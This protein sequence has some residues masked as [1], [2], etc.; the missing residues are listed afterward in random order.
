MPSIATI[1]DPARADHMFVFAVWVIVTLYI[2]FKAG[3]VKAKNQHYIASCIEIFCCINFI[4]ACLFWVFILFSC[5]IIILK[6]HVNVSA[7]TPESIVEKLESVNPEY[8]IQNR[9]N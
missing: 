6:E 3:T 1:I 9:K 4:V 7:V 8:K 2:S 5:L